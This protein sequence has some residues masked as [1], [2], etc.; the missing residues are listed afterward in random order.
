MRRLLIAEPA[1]VARGAHL[2]LVAEPL[3]LLGRDVHPR[4]FRRGRSWMWGLGGHEAIVPVSAGKEAS[5]TLSRLK[6]VAP[7]SSSVVAVSANH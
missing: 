1:L 3:Q 7:E 2:L 4:R 6:L 5:L